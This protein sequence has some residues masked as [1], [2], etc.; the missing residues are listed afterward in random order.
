MPSARIIHC[1]RHPLDNI[2]SML[3]ANLTAGNNYTSDPLDA[4]KFLIHQED[5]MNKFKSTYEKH[6]YTFDYDAFTSNPQK[7]LHP[8]INW[9]GL[10]WSERYLHPETNSRLINTAS[11]IQARQPITSKS[12]GG[13]KNYRELL[14]P[15]EEALAESG[16]FNL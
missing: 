15:A 11:V 7:T 4:A 9:L 3:R 16:I 6:I 5:T 12:V 13:W 1:R 14:K 2:L 10:K 8:L